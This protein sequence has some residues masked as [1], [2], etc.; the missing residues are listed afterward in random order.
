MAYKQ[1]IHDIKISFSDSSASDQTIVNNLTQQYIITNPNAY[2]SSRINLIGTNVFN[3][4]DINFIYLSSENQISAKINNQTELILQHLSYI[5]LSET[6]D[7]ILSNVSGQMNSEIQLFYG[8]I[9]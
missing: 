3:I 6:F 1:I 7:V 4:D 5:N 9:S 8:S 2:S